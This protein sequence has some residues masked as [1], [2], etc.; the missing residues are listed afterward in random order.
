MAVIKAYLLFQKQ[1]LFIRV[2]VWSKRI[3][4]NIKGKDSMH[5]KSKESGRWESRKWRR[6]GRREN[7]SNH[8][9]WILPLKKSSHVTWN[10][11]LDLAK[12]PLHNEYLFIMNTASVLVS[13]PSIQ[14]NLKSML[15]T[16]AG[17]FDYGVESWGRRWGESSPEGLSCALLDRGRWSDPGY[18]LFSMFF[19]VMFYNFEFNCDSWFNCIITI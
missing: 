9:V 11:E 10:G 18:Q 6:K 13:P 16:Q 1:L 19:Y 2:S 17:G 8:N 4:V 14:T 12:S 7:L 15:V 3:K 5:I